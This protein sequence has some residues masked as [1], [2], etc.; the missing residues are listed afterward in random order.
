MYKKKGM[1]KG[2]EKN[3]AKGVGGNFIV[4]HRK[5]KK[6][7]STPRGKDRLRGHGEDEGVARR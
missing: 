7:E 1:K 2:K 6:R 3:M 4:E 5:E